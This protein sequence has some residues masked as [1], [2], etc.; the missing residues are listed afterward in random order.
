MFNIK[1]ELT[2]FKQLD[3]PGCEDSMSKKK[4][5]EFYIPV[6]QKYFREKAEGHITDQTT[7]ATMQ[8]I[9]D[10]FM[11]TAYRLKKVELG[12]E[13]FRNRRKV[14]EFYT[15]RGQMLGIDTSFIKVKMT[16]DEIFE[17]WVEAFWKKVEPLL[18]NPALGEWMF[19]AD[20]TESEMFWSFL[21]GSGGYLALETAYR[22]GFDPV[23]VFKETSLSDHLSAWTYRDEGYL[24]TKWRDDQFMQQIM[25]ATDIL[26]LGAG[27]MPEIRR[28]GYL[29]Q[30]NFWEDQN[31]FAC[32]QDPRIDFDFL[33]E[34]LDPLAR[35]RIDYRK[36]S[37]SDMLVQM[38]AEGRTFDLIYVKGVISFMKDALAPLIQ[39]AMELLNPGGK[40]MFDMQLSHFVMARDALYF[41]WGGGDSVAKIELLPLEEALT[42]VNQT[43]KQLNISED[44]IS[45][46]VV[47]LDPIY[48][49]PF[50]MNII[51]T[52]TD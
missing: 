52:K 21:S 31:F 3:Y 32:D 50:G 10:D 23:G 15:H 46:P 12:A 33:T 22:W 36:I 8:K 28:T 24:F 30:H 14:A 5:I 49:D 39:A 42:F 9:K 1:N 40:F 6:S 16:G 18:L 13:F 17:Q 44:R 35:S 41:G 26:S 19:A 20:M 7:D 29:T 34:S 27:G 51:V 2:M 48:R 45:D 38:Q 43:A 25:E 4:A 47:M 11:K 37:I